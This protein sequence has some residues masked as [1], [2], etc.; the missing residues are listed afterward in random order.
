[1][2]IIQLLY[3]NFKDY[4]QQIT[5]GHGCREPFFLFPFCLF[6]FIL[7]HTTMQIEKNSF[8]GPVRKGFKPIKRKLGVKY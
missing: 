2:I 8:L 6:R 4:D 1:M 7:N 3:F 5:I